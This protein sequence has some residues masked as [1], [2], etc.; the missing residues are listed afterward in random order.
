MTYGLINEGEN[1]NR[2][3]GGGGGGSSRFWDIYFARCP[4]DIRNG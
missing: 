2:I 4:Y 1:V 3:I